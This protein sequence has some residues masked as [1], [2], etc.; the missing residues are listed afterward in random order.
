MTER[1]D[2][3]TENKGSMPEYQVD[4][5][6]KMPHAYT[7]GG[8]MKLH[9]GLQRYPKTRSLRGHTRASC[10]W[11]TCTCTSASAKALAARVLLMIRWMGH[12]T[13]R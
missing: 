5:D 12:C 13:A 2:F 6:R 9:P 3:A 7:P 8:Q 1:V 4:L 10:L 11:G